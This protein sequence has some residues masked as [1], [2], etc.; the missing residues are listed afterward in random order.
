MTL[1]LSRWHTCLIFFFFSFSRSL[2]SSLYHH[3]RKL[4]PKIP[5]TAAEFLEMLDSSGYEANLLGS[6]Q[7]GDQLAVLFLPTA[8]KEVLSTCQEI[9][10]DGTFYCCPAQFSQIF[11]VFAVV[12]EYTFPCCT[13]LMTAKSQELYEAVFAKLLESVP[14]MQPVL[15]I[16]DF[17]QASGNA[18]KTIFPD[19]RVSG[20]SFHFMQA[21]LRMAR[22]QGLDNAFKTNARFRKLLKRMMHSNFLPANQIPQALDVLLR[23]E[24]GLTVEHELKG[25]RKLKKYMRTFWLNRVGS[26]IL[27]V[28]GLIRKTNNGAECH[29]SRLKSRILSHRPRVWKFLETYNLMMVDY[30]ADIARVQN[31]VQIARPRRPKNVE[32]SERRRIAEEKLTSGKNNLYLLSRVRGKRFR[33]FNAYCFAIKSSMVKI[34][35]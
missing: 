10:F 4:Q 11:T 15:A 31:G 29:H 3:R 24:S 17:E 20:C 27:S 18:I 8:M 34:Q 2:E 12:G 9:S 28:F 7:V 23:E 25:F 14:T 5:K 21:T 30:C 33:E 32:N 26:D 16:G 35:H 1:Y 22:K 6:V 13:V 19:I